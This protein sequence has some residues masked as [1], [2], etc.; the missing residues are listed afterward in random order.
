MINGNIS[1]LKDYVLENLEKIYEKKIEKGKILDEET[2]NYISEI[3]NKINREINI[4]IDRNGNVIDISIGDSSTVN[5]PLIPVYDKKLSGVRIVH[6]HPGG[7][8]HLS[9]VDV[10]AL[11]K[12]K[13]DCI[14]SIGVSDNGITGYEVAICSIVNDELSYDRTPL[15][16]LNSFD[17]LDEIKEVEELLRKREIKEDDSEYAILVGIDEEK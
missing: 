11:I 9:S 1:G 3:S 2:A 6:T 14:V 5:L 17:Y 10:S 12:L 7:N 16:D 4:A 15:T 13:L 8:P